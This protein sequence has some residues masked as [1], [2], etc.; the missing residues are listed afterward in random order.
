MNFVMKHLLTNQNFYK[1]KVPLNGEFN[2]LKK[3]IYVNKATLQIYFLFS[4]NA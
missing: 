3:D 1:F 4:L 2:F